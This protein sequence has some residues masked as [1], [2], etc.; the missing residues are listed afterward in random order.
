MLFSYA[1]TF[2]AFALCLGLGGSIYTN[3]EQTI[4][5]EVINRHA[6]LFI[7]FEKYKHDPECLIVSSDSLY[8]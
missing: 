5:F 3:N 8:R 4:S 2:R 6:N 1:S 7:T